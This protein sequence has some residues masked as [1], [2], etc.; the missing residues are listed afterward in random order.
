MNLKK[1][2]FNFFYIVCSHF[3]KVYDMIDENITECEPE[4]PPC[5][6]FNTVEDVS[7]F[8]AVD[9]DTYTKV[10]KYFRWPRG[11]SL[12]YAVKITLNEAMAP[13]CAFNYTMYGTSTTDALDNTLIR[14][15]L[16]HKKVDKHIY[17]EFYK[18]LPL[19]V[20]QKSQNFKLEAHL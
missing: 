14:K 11:H 18:E 12:E 1:K 16:Y 15:A 5:L 6:P 9:N 19:T 7:A 10:I 2:K 4:K 20:V 3:R 8:E 17:V 13:A